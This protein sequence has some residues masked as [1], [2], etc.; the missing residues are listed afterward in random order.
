MGKPLALELIN[1]E[2]TV[3]SCNIFTKNLAQTTSKADIVVSAAGVAGLIT[4]E[5]VRKGA[6]VIDVGS[7]YI[8]NPDLDDIILG[9]FDVIKNFA[10]NESEVEEGRTKLIRALI[11]TDPRFK[12]LSFIEA[13]RLF[14]KYTSPTA[15]VGDVMYS[16]VKDK[17]SAISPVPGGVGPNTVANLL[18]NT[19]MLCLYQNVKDPAE[20]GLKN[21]KGMD[22][23][24]QKRVRRSSANA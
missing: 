18:Q 19:V 14:S 20:Y 11:Q 7:N 1:R 9:K 16:L 10:A 4:P 2:A 17:C 6:V 8:V 15:Y 21:P 13:S 22:K 3:L 5:H 23:T 24:Q 12:D